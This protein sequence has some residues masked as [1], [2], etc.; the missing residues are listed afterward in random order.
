MESQLGSSHLATSLLE[1]Q[2]DEW[3]VER[4]ITNNPEDTQ[5]NDTGSRQ[6]ETSSTRIPGEGQGGNNQALPAAPYHPLETAD[7]VRTIYGQQEGGGR[8]RPFDY[9]H[10]RSNS[11]GWTQDG[12]ESPNFVSSIRMRTGTANLGGRGSGR[13]GALPNGPGATTSRAVDSRLGYGGEIRSELRLEEHDASEQRPHALS[14]SGLRQATTRMGATR[15]T[16]RSKRR[17][18]RDPTSSHSLSAPSVSEASTR[19]RPHPRYPRRSTTTRTRRATSTGRMTSTATTDTHAPPPTHTTSARR[20]TCTP[21]AQRPASTTAAA[22]NREG[23]PAT[24]ATSAQAST[25]SAAASREGSPDTTAT[26]A[27]TPE[28]PSPTHTTGTPAAQRLAST[29]STAASRE[30]SPTAVRVL[31]ARRARRLRARNLRL[32]PLDARWDRLRTRHLRPRRR[33]QL[34]P[35]T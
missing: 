26:T 28:A 18:L 25:T 11:N 9:N 16:T 13:V 12:N 15:R 5:L 1:E 2:L 19:R 23:P 33:R 7:A 3:T 29:T 35:C 34:R 8:I 14:T 6:Q 31:N 17:Q 27:A 10:G 20:P 4:S 32:H 30:G 24:T 21:A 22:A